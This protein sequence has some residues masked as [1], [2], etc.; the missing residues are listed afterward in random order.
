[1]M[2]YQRMLPCGKTSFVLGLGAVAAIGEDAVI[3]R[4]TLGLQEVDISSHGAVRNINS[5]DAVIHSGKRNGMFAVVSKVD[6]EIETHKE[7]K[8]AEM[9]HCPVL[10]DFVKKECQ[11]DH[12]NCRAEPS[13]AASASLC[14]EADTTSDC[15]RAISRFASDDDKVA[16]W[17]HA[18]C[19]GKSSLEQ[20]RA[21]AEVHSSMLEDSVGRKGPT[22]HPTPPP[23]RHPTPH[24]TDRKSVV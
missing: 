3:R 23:T 10:V 14:K 12:H 20:R 1:M 17:Y 19:Q 4:S 8:E 6:G 16:G 2:S 15:K 18:F 21:S 11:G 9:Q 24:P 22:P 5:D 7:L 13:E